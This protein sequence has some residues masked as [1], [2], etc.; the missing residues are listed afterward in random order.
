M[1][2][3]HLL[4][5]AAADLYAVSGCGPDLLEVRQTTSG[6]ND[7]LA[8]FGNY[9]TQH[10]PQTMTGEPTTRL[11][12]HGKSLVLSLRSSHRLG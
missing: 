1:K 11:P 10:R 12:S 3:W 2:R 5:T 6:L 4:I 8:S 9:T 7:L